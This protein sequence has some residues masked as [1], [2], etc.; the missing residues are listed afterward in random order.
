MIKMDA[1]ELKNLLLNFALDVFGD[2]DEDCEQV[3]ELLDDHT[4]IE[5]YVDDYM[6]AKELIDLEEAAPEESA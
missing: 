1:Y 3:Q 2:L 4:A 5:D 6:A